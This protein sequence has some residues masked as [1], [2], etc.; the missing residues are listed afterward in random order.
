MTVTQSPG[1]AAV[2]GRLWG[3]R[4]R[5][6]A[7]LQ[8]HQKAHEYQ[9]VFDQVELGAATEYCDVGCASGV[10]AFMAAQRGAQVSGLDAADALIEIARARVP[11]ANFHVGE[12]E[13]LPFGDC[14]FDVVTGFHA[15][16][17]AAR[18]VVA[19]AEARRVAKRDGRI[20]M[21][22]WGPPEGMDVAGLIDALTPLL[23]SRPPGSLGIYALSDEGALRALAESAGLE[24]LSDDYV[25]CTWLYPNRATALR[26]F[27]S[28]GR[29]V[30][31]IECS[32]ESAVDR[33]HADALATF[34]VGDG[35][36]RVEATSI[37][38]LARPR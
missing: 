13:A 35:G 36:Y 33:A 7:D 3:A 14:T 15:F 24:P 34:R 23:P 19:L 26:A 25:A 5:D 10:A 9:T 16:N 22:T 4:A 17:Y 37:C 20:V 2:H 1:S 6:W 31:A 29:A 28:S 38:L 21:T 30:R 12:M 27:A 18:P 11:S 8:E 32:S